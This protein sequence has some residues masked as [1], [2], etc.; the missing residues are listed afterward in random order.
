MYRIAN[1]SVESA[2]IGS[3]GSVGQFSPTRRR[4]SN[5]KV[6]AHVNGSIWGDIETP[7]RPYHKAIGPDNADISPLII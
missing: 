6:D 5:L 2:T 4:A 7:T 3:V 1:S